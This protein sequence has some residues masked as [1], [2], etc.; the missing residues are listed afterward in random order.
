MNEESSQ[1]VNEKHDEGNEV[2]AS[3]TK[4]VKGVSRGEVGKG[5]PCVAS[6]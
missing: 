2:T 4:S 3:C 6:E 5:R 1:R